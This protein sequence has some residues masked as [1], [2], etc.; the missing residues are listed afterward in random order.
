MLDKLDDFKKAVQTYC[1]ECISDDDLEK[2]LYIDT[3]LYDDEWNYDLIKNLE[4]L[5][6]FGE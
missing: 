6:P 1:N 4:D 2:I 3:K 5:A